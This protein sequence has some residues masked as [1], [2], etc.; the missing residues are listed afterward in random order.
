[1]TQ[2]ADKAID[3]MCKA[4]YDPLWGML[5]DAKIDSRHAMRAAL[6]TLREPSDEIIDRGMRA[7]AVFGPTG[8]RHVA[9]IFRAMIAAAI[10][11]KP[12]AE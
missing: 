3:A 7:G 11:E 8:A 2:P 6:A 12:D 5:E 10:E 1:M 9:R 4:F